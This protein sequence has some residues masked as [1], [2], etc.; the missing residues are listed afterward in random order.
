MVTAQNGQPRTLRPYQ[1]EAVS[2]VQDAWAYSTDARPGVV[3]PTGTGKQQPVSTPIPT[4]DG[5]RLL[6]ELSVGDEVFAA[7]GSATRIVAV[8]EQGVKPVFRMRFDDGTTAD[9]GPEHLWSVSPERV[10]LTEALRCVSADTVP[11][12]THVGGVAKTLSSL[13]GTPPLHGDDITYTMTTLALLDRVE[14]GERWNIQVASPAQYRGTVFSAQ[15][16]SSVGEMAYRRAWMVS[17]DDEGIPEKFLT[18]PSPTRWKVL[19]GM[20]LASRT[21]GEALFGHAEIKCRSRSHGPDSQYV[22]LP[23]GRLKLCHDVKRLVWSLGGLVE[24]ETLPVVGGSARYVRLCLHFA[25]AGRV[26]DGAFIRRVVSVEPLPD[27]KKCRCITVEHPDGLYLT[28]YEHIVTHNS[29]VIAKLA[30][31]ARS[32][33]KRVVLLAHRGELLDQM[34]E[35]VAAVEPDG[36]EV[37]IVAGRRDNPDTAIVAASFQTLSRHKRLSALEKRDLVIAD[38]CHHITAS[39][40]KK[41]LV[42]LRALPDV[43]ESTGIEVAPALARTAGFTATMSRADGKHLGDVWS[44]VVYERD[45]MWAI[46]SGYLVAPRGKAVRIDGLN[47]LASIR[48]Q[49]GDYR[50][51]ELGDVMAA[52]VPTTV[53]A[54]IRHASGRAAIVF[55]VS[56]AHAHMIAEQ[57]NSRG[58]SAEAVTGAMCLD[59]RN[60]VYSAFRAGT[61]NAMVTVAVLTE[62]ADFPRCDTVVMA[63][64]TRS[65]VL[66]CQ[67]LGRALRPYPGKSDALVLDLTGSSR[68]MSMVTL[69]KLHPS[70]PVQ[71]VDVDGNEITDP[72]PEPDVGEPRRRKERIGVV[73]LEDIDLLNRSSGNWLKTP[74]GVRFLD[75][76]SVYLFIWPPN[77]TPSDQ[78]ML[79]KVPQNSRAYEWFKDPSGKPI[80]S[81]LADA[82]A[83]AEWFAEHVY[84]GYSKQSAAWRKKAAP[85]EAQIGYAKVLGIPDAEIKT[86]ARLSDDISI[87]K[88]SRSIPVPS[89]WS[90]PIV[91]AS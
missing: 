81:S 19:N 18:A 77:P 83:G 4:P 38:E 89:G 61:I 47:K 27:P 55:A 65:Q 41:V 78:C 43:D 22:V 1:L 90:P 42:D 91:S 11:I 85:S 8:H 28:G 7:D 34:A 52:S 37:G 46:D 58:F 51:S 6:G 15:T 36:E 70:S 74:A 35:A 48:N 57:L 76:K 49:M 33:G 67:I 79:G 56:V 86:R 87:A 5:M 32:E 72:E 40:Y 59:S 24:Q 13:G 73:S 26:D 84:H 63:R 9:S 23:R 64:P 10:N 69:S 68:D 80:V 66:Y 53:D 14:K 82:V 20:L 45:V 3:L 88:A 30:T 75:A 60:T 29:T 39:T 54:V 12:G 17:V 71:V 16:L 62:G 2:A 21:M 25:P 50:L 31:D 44:D